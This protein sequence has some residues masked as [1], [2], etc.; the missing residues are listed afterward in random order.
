MDAALTFSSV[1]NETLHERLRIKSNG[2]V[3]IG[4]NNPGAV[5]HIDSPSVNAHT[6]LLRLQMTSGWSNSTG[7]NKNIVWADG[8]KVAAIGTAYDGS[9][10]NM[11][12]HSFYNSGYKADTDVLMLSLIHI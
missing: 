12:F 8:T 11:H 5:L 7:K 2:N 6:D 10:V 3:G 9:K 4:T 1:E